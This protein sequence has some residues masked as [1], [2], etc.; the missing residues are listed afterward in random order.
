MLRKISPQFVREGQL[1]YLTIL[2]KKAHMQGRL[3]LVASAAF[4]KATLS[5]LLFTTKKTKSVVQYRW[6][7][8]APQ[9]YENLSTTSLMQVK[10]F[11]F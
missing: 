4:L 6:V 11:L 7:W 5:L 3:A 8:I 9:R 2:A 10:V 1:R